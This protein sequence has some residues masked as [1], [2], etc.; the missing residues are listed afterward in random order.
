M[1]NPVPQNNQT[2][3][4]SD[5]DAIQNNRPKHAD[6]QS[7]RL[8]TIVLVLVFFERLIHFVAHERKQANSPSAMPEN[9]PMMMLRFMRRRIC[10]SR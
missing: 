10:F 2:E 9:T 4:G 3:S 7:A 8:A 5:D 6:K 1:P